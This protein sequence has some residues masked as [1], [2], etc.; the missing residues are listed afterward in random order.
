MKPRN[1]FGGNVARK[2]SQRRC[3]GV[4]KSWSETKRMTFKV[5]DMRKLDSEV[6]WFQLT[7]IEMFQ[8]MA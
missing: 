1:K 5:L 6:G 7:I 8:K 2:K 4:G 3:Q